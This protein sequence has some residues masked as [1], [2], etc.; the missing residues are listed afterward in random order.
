MIKLIRNTLLIILTVSFTTG[1]KKYLDVAPDNIGTIDYAFRMRTEAEKYLF[2]LYNNLPS[3][4][5]IGGNPGLLSGDEFAGPYPNGVGLDIS[6][7]R[8]ARGEQ[9]I[10]SPI[11]NYW[12]GQNGGKPYFRAMRECGIFLENIERVP[13][14]SQ[15]EKRRWIAEANILKAYYHFFLLR[16]YGPIPVMRENL[17][18]SATIEDVRVSR[19]PVDSV[20][21]YIVQLVDQSTP[22]LPTEIV[23]EASELG[24]LNK[25]I[26]LS[27]KAQALM[28]NASPLFNGN[29]DYG[30]LKNNDGLNL[31]NPTVDASKWE[32]AALACKEAIDL[33]ESTGGTLYL[34]EPLS[35]EN[36][37]DST[38]YTMNIRGALSF[39]WNEETIWGGTNSTAS[40]IQSFAQAR[41]ISGDPSKAPNPPTTN[42]AIRSLLAVPLHIADIFYSNNG[43]PIEEDRSYDYTNRHTRL[44]TA[45]A[46]DR[47]YLKEGYTTA[48]LNFDREPRYYADLAFD[49]GIWFGQGLYDDNKTWHM[50]AKAGQL[51]ARLG[52]SNYTV[53]GYLPK[54]LVNYRNDFGSNSGSYNT[55]YYPWPI[56]RLAELYL[57][58]AEA[59][60][61]VSGPSP[62]VYD[63]L[64]RI[65]TRAGLKGVIE[66]WNTHS[67][68]PTKPTTKEGLRSIIQQETMIELMFEGKRFW[69]LKRWKRSIEFQNK[70]I[71]GWDIEQE[72]TSNYYRVRQIFAPVFTSKDYLWPISESAVVRN[73][74]LVQNPGW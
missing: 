21:S 59:T 17:P 67:N 25:I 27:I 51:G 54:K 41:L 57:W 52:S 33:A 3:L 9:N 64:D 46:K 20:V 16:M 18:V 72:T 53:T 37:T 4:A 62:E 48:Q 44:R 22:D 19:E 7:Y 45:E 39:K 14:I 30:N 65:R 50:E 43:V 61:E 5:E 15:I 28:L 2:T 24:R 8:I 26:A 56:I 73:P 11:A 69:D 47:Y 34:F 63:Y 12:D 10:V 38:R 49:G 13:D 32:R 60:N 23:N 68:N 6:L 31:F 40:G 74:N 66:S 35:G 1:C 58:F 55:L 36:L 29:N 42:E 71:Q 70:S